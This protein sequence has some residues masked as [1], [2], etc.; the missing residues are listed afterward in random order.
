M[1]KIKIPIVF[2]FDDNFVSQAGV[3]ITSLLLNAKSETF[4][5]IF[6]IHDNKSLFPSQGKLEH[7]YN[8]FSNF[9]ITYRNVKNTFQGAFEIRDINV[10]TYYRLLIPELI[11]EYDKIMYHD[12]DVIFRNDLS[13]IFNE[14]DLTDFY[15]SG[16]VTPKPLAPDKPERSKIGFDWE[17]Y[18]LA[19]NI[20]F[21]S[22][23]LRKDGVVDVFKQ[24]VLNSK[25]EYQDMDIINLVCKNKVKRMPP[26]FCGTI[27]VFDLAVKKEIQ[28]LYTLEELERVLSFGI[29]HYN[30]PKPWNTWCLNFDI[31]WEYYRKSVYF[32]ENFYYNFFKSKIN[33]YD[34]LSLKKRMKILFRYFKNG[35]TVN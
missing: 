20:I 31:W 26:E 21:N 18:I 15:V 32:D 17:S 6:V 4:Y 7:L 12:V 22:E 29:V 16:V 2:C 8:E 11:P 3:C 35:K 30:G 10:A 25:Y 9:S 28:T 34:Q 1:E 5:D 33:E 27:E 14:T 24:T 13:D 19:G 23:L